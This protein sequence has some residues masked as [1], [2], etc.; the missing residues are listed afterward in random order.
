MSV[1]NLQHLFEPESVAV[2][3]A[4]NRP[5]SVGFA[6]M[7]NMLSG[8]FEGPVMPVN[9]S[10]QAVA[11]VLTYP[12]VAYGFESLPERQDLL[13]ELAGLGGLHLPQGARDRG[14]Q[15]GRCVLVDLLAVDR[16]EVGL[17]PGPPKDPDAGPE[18]RPEP[19]E[20]YFSF[21]LANSTRKRGQPTPLRNPSYQ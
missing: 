8:G 17:L 2:V 3:G 13:F 15:L 10:H 9:P 19:V 4:S 7:Q 18:A 21:C 20:G 6:V 16:E 11:G 12:D 5:G 14:E 1:R